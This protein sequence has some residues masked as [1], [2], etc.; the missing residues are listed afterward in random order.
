MTP[1]EFVDQRLEAILSHPDGWGP[2]HAVE[3]QVLLLI[4]MGHIAHGRT[5]DHVYGVTERFSRHLGQRLPG[6]PLPLAH[7]LGLKDSA[8]DRFVQVLRDFIEAE[9]PRQDS[10]L[11]PPD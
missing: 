1:A 7:R 4:E 11:Q 3:L 6:P 9:Y 10:N 5:E 2:P 8:N